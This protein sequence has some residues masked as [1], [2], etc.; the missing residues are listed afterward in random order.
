MRLA[1]VAFAVGILV[2]AGTHSAPA[3]KKYGPGVTDTEIKL[4]Q[5]MPYSGPAS[6]LSIV[7]R[8]EA[9]YFRMLNAKG[10]VNGRKIDLLS[11]DDAFSPSKT[12]EQTRSLVEGQEV[13]ATF[14]SMGS[15][16]NL[17]AAKYLNNAKVPQL[18]VVAGS[19]KLLDPVNQ[20]WTTTFYATLALEAKLLALYLRQSNPNARIGILYSTDEAGKVYLEGLKAGLGDKASTMLVKE[21]SFDLAAPTIDS[22]ILQLQAAKVDTLFLGIALPK[23]GAQGIRKVSELGWKPQLVLSQGTQGIDG[24]LRPAGLENAVGAVTSMFQKMPDDS[25]WAND[26]AM[27]EYAAFMKQ[28][29]PNENASDQL[30]LVGYSAAQL[31]VEVIKRCGEELT[32]ENLLEKATSIGNYQLPLFIPG[33]KINVTSQ[34]RSPWKQ[35]QMARFNGKTWELFGGIVSAQGD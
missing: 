21:I 32:R 5:T 6:G 27:T 10:G 13:L 11:V 30:A 18:F 15:S 3:Q 26:P 24:V 1:S 35:T 28:W 23:F 16:P 4:G 29:A 9:A 22:E 14:S 7:G 2:V 12:V 34:D 17:A 33:I 31:M 20:P 19:P 8:V 25:Q